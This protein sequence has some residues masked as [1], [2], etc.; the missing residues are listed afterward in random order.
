MS[1]LFKSPLLVRRLNYIVDSAGGLPWGLPWVQV[2]IIESLWD[3]PSARFWEPFH[4]EF[5][6][7]PA[8]GTWPIRIRR[9]RSSRLRRFFDAFRLHK[10]MLLEYQLPGTTAWLQVLRTPA[11][12]LASQLNVKDLAAGITLHVRLMLSQGV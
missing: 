9:R 11:I 7:K 3:E 8:T 4:V 5:R 1:L 2:A 12:F 10:P 6:D